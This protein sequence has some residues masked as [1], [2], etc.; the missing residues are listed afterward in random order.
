MFNISLFQNISEVQNLL[1]KLVYFG[2]LIFILTVIW[3]IHNFTLKKLRKKIKDTKIFSIWRFLITMFTIFISI[4]FTTVAFIDNLAVFFGSLSL[5][6]AALVF[7]LQDF[8]S[9]FFAWIYIE[10]SRQYAIGETILITS[11]NRQL[12]GTITEVGIFRTK[13]QEKLG[14]MSLDTE[15]STG[16]LL[17]FPNNFIFKHS[18]TNV[19]KNHLLLGHKFKVVI[20]F[21]TNYKKANQVIEKAVHKVFEELLKKPE[22][23]FDI[24]VV[25]LSNYI[26]QVYHN[27]EAS[28]VAFTVWF[29]CRSGRLRQVLEV[30]SSGLLDAFL[31]NDIHMAYDTFRIIK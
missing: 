1:S 2:I 6:S 19:T 23:Y 20:T 15:M 3:L 29:G 30:Y 16:R 14:D 9:C 17:T 26:P 31:E 25:D 12:Y 28:G 22:R 4:V 24:E 21:E 11:D 27:I 8:V 13:L 10:L 18:L 7:A 5:L